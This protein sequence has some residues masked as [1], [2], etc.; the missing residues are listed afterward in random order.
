M[1]LKPQMGDFPVVQ[2]LRLCAFTA[3]GSGSIPP[4]GELS[5]HE[6]LCSA[7]NR[8]HRWRW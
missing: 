5:P 3:K 2:W 4:S 6:L 8:N 1:C 7:K